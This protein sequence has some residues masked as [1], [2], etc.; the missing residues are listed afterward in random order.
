MEINSLFVC[1]HY[2]SFYQSLS[3]ISLLH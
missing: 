2:C 3:L 1:Y